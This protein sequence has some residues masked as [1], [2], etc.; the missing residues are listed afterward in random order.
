M[1]YDRGAVL[2][3]FQPTWLVDRF[4][5][6]SV[7]RSYDAVL[8]K[9]CIHN[10]GSATWLKREIENRISKVPLISFVGER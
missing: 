2:G 8:L 7:G 5:L 1:V 4:F 10:D 3:R 6:E 9:I